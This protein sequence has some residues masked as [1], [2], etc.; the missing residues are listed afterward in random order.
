MT[1]I[2]IVIERE[3]LPN[4]TDDE[5]Y[6]HQ[7]IGMTVENTQGMVLG[8]VKDMLATGANDVMIVDGEKRSLIPYVHGEFVLS[9]DNVKNLITVNWD[10]DF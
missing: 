6:W 2:E 9:I 5:Y 7:L 10:E 1:N 4:L 8:R 3:Q